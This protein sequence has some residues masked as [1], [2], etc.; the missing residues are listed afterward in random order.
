MAKIRHPPPNQ[1]SQACTA[2]TT[3][4]STA[5]RIRLWRVI[6]RDCTRY[7]VGAMKRAALA[8]IRAQR[9]SESPRGDGQMFRKMLAMVRKIPYGKVATYGQVAYAAGFPGA[10]RQVSWALHGGSGVPWHRVIGAGGNIL[11]RGEA[12]FEQRMRLRAEGV[13]FAGQRA[14][15]GKHQHNFG[16]SRRRGTRK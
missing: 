7:N 9:S 10:A 1:I 12:G 6:S 15:I 13:A 3:G 5:S 11:L 8:A 2:S 14:L 16:P 4:S